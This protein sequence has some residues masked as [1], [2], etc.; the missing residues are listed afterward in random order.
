MGHTA[1]VHRGRS[2]GMSPDPSERERDT[3]L[4]PDALVA[5][6]TDRLGR[7]GF[8]REVG[9]AATLTDVIDVV[10]RHPDLFVD[11]EHH[12]ALL[13]A[14]SEIDSQYGELRRQVSEAQHLAMVDPLTGAANRRAFSAR[15]DEHLHGGRD[16]R[17]PFAL[18]ILDLDHFKDLNDRHG[19]AAGD[20]VLKVV[21]ETLHSASRADDMVARVGGEEFAVMLSGADAAVATTVF[22]RIRRTIAERPIPV[23]GATLHI[24][25]S[26]GV[27]TAGPDDS[28][29]DHVF[30]RADAALYDAKRSG[31]NQ[32]VFRGP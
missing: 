13:D 6:V 29:V 23:D 7:L 18:G 2:D 9:D 15:G 12:A 1:R 27:T 8:V 25:A 22:E 32:V 5:E 30:A 10:A 3:D 17:T 24:T 11:E 28:D 20:E 31:R 14:L 19:H 16:V 26:I 21:V 4:P